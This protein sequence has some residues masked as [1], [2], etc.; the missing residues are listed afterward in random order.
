MRPKDR[1]Y[2]DSSVLTSATG[3]FEFTLATVSPADPLTYG[4]VAAGLILAAA[5]ASYLPARSATR[6]DPVEALR[7]E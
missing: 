4:V 3:K 1:S 2:T 5:L 6:V 7:A